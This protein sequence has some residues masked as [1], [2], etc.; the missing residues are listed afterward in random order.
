MAP[1][2][3]SE[4]VSEPIPPPVPADD[5]RTPAGAGTDRA[6]EPA[7]DQP[8]S[9]PGGGGSPWDVSG[10]LGGFSKKMGSLQLP[11]WL[12][13]PDKVLASDSTSGQAS[14]Q[15]ATPK[16]GEQAIGK[17]TA[18][19]K[20][21]DQHESL[22]VDMLHRTFPLKMEPGEHKNPD[23]G[24]SYIV[25]ASGRVT[26][27]TTG[28]GMKYK[29]IRYDR[30]GEIMSYDAPSG[31]HFSRITGSQ[32][33]DKDG[34]GTWQCTDGQGRRVA[35][36][37]SNS[38]SWRGKCVADDTGF[39]TMI[40]SGP[41]KGAMYSRGG[42]GTAVE[43]KFIQREGDGGT[44][45]CKVVLPDGT[46]ML[47]N[48]K[49]QN[50]ELT[51]NPQ[52]RVTNADK[53]EATTLTMDAAGTNGNVVSTEKLKSPA[54]KAAADKAAADK[55]AADKAASAKGI[56]DRV[57]QRIGDSSDPIAD[58]SSA[59]KNMDKLRGATISRIER[60][61]YAGKHQVEMHFD[62][63]TTAPAIR[64]NIN[65]FRPGPTTIDADIGFILSHANGGIHLERMQGFSGYVTGPMG[66][67]RDSFNNGMFIGR[68]QNGVPF[69]NVDSSVQGVFRMRRSQ[70][71]FRESQFPEDSPIR[72]L[73][74][75]P[76]VL[77]QVAGALRMFQNTDDLSTV[78]LTRSAKGTFDVVA[79]GNED[80]H[81]PINQK[82]EQ[83][84]ATIESIDLAKT[85][86]ATISHDDKNVS[87]SNIKGF[88]V[89]VK[90]PL[91]EMKV[92]PKMV[93]LQKNAQG[94]PV[95]HVE[96]D[97]PA[98]PGTNMPFDIPVAKLKEMAS[99]K[100]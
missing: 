34:F 85:L 23:D 94:E 16:P 5:T 33:V 27:Y 92:T 48:A 10:L 60:G 83:F 17:A 8:G 3:Q 51:K 68:D 59:L 29:N 66:R 77:Q 43:S 95:V 24:S 52:V 50:G 35:Y 14:D 71:T 89:T 87:L 55:A 93:A 2:N 21:A 91:G 70:N 88:C 58:L 18:A 15:P 72:H 11:S 86:S 100:R 13:S 47:R 25:D 75:N 49:L 74:K 1:P 28:N 64:A 73:M 84:G 78:K 26:E 37:G 98:Q 40:G 31:H 6:T 46:E 90:S 36:A 79:E 4:T 12:A 41:N 9:N 80:K 76:D 81:I 39:H 57:I 65:G 32:Q 53:T 38:W 56:A 96:I 69:V 19:T 67:Q 54:D 22:Y 61:H 63:A 42:D 62:H 44:L 30:N 82:L 45:Q 99:K 7:G 97:N 20:H